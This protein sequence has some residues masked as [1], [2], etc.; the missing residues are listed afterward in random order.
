MSHLTQLSIKKYSIQRQTF[1][2]Y[3]HFFSYIKIKIYDNA[4]LVFHSSSLDT[5]IVS[6][7]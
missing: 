7:S 5:V 1:L 2:C 6:S 4:A 3:L